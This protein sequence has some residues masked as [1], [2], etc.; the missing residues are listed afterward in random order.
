MI[1]LFPTDE[2]CP[3]CR[4]VCLDRFGEHVVHC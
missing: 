4:K 3:V 1:S 2:V